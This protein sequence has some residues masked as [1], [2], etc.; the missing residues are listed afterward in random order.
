MLFY[1]RLSA[2]HNHNDIKNTSHSDIHE[3]YNFM[4]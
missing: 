1:T 2:G 3:F 4:L